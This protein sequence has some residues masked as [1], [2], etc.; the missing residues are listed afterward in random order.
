MHVIHLIME[1]NQIL[2]G[3]RRDLNEL[4]DLSDCQLNC[5]LASLAQVSQQ[6]DINNIEDLRCK[7]LSLQKPAGDSKPF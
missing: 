3:I 1:W 4:I 5:A 7:L 6:L 2:G